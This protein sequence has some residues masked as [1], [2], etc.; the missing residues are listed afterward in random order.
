[1]QYRGCSPTEE[2]S[3]ALIRFVQMP[4]IGSIDIAVKKALQVRDSSSSYASWRE[5]D[6]RPRHEVRLS[7]GKRYASFLACKQLFCRPAVL[8]VEGSW[9][10]AESLSCQGEEDTP[11][12]RWEQPVFVKHGV[13]S[14]VGE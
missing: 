2:T 8:G 12:A 11:F 9:V 4:W 5:K 10:S 1:M 6:R 13:G 14:R 7:V 3:I